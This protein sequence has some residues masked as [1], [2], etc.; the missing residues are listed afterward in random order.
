MTGYAPGAWET[1]AAA[2]AGAAAALAGLLFVGVTINVETI[3]AS[4]RLTGRALEAFVL[5]TS[6][7]IVSVLVLIPKISATGLGIA[8]AIA[9]VSIWA[10]VTRLHV[11]A[12]PRFGGET[13]TYAPPGS[14]LARIAA[15]QAATVPTIV[16]AVTLLAESGGGLYWLVG[17]V[18]F[19]YTAALANAWVLLIEIRR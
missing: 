7:L 2:N 4:R 14:S 17:A 10:I 1:F 16:A 6:V 11:R 3:V 13:D 12:L 9:G 8:L 18:V 5:L 19:A 15:G